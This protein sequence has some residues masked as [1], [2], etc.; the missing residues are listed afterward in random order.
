[1]LQAHGATRTRPPTAST[2]A[3]RYVQQ[4]SRVNGANGMIVCIVATATSPWQMQTL[5]RS[6]LFK[7]IQKDSISAVPKHGCFDWPV[8][9]M[10]G[11]ELI[12]AATPCS[13]AT[14][15]STA[16]RRTGTT[17]RWARAWRAPSR[18]ASS[19]AR[20]CGSRASQHLSCYTCPGYWVSL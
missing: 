8:W 7:D 18:T 11:S 15:T 9:P 2:M 4:S 13:W 20:T 3:S 1:M 10:H 16:R 17:R 14:G 6:F 5:D 19:S 12:S